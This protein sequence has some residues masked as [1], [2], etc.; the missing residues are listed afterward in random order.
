MSIGVRRRWLWMAGGIG[1]LGGTLH[2]MPA[3]WLGVALERFTQGKVL[4]LNT[5]GTVWRGQGDLVLS[6]GTGSRSNLGLPGG[7]AWAFSPAWRSAALSIDV[8]APCCTPHP[9]HAELRWN[10]LGL[11]LS[12]QDHRSQWPA[13]WLTGWEGPWSLMRLSGHLQLET[14]DLTFTPQRQAVPVQGLLQIDALQLSSALSTLRPLGDYRLS[15]KGDQQGLQMDLQTLNGDLNLS[16]KGQWSDGGMRFRGV[17]EASPERLNV[18]STLL[19]LLGRR[20]GPRA[21]ISLE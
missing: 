7:I 16:G 19:N 3:Q 1:L 20:D 17:A 10:G 14:Q 6:G 13:Q 4:L 8:Q 2:A 5:S 11:S 21:Y 18:L 9:I 12:V 15:L